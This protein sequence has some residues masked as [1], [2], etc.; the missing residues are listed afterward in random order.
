MPVRIS[1]GSFSSSYE[2]PD[3]VADIADEQI[4]ACAVYFLEHGP[5]V[6]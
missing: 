2:R 5:Q 4:A 1:S 6:Y 3:L